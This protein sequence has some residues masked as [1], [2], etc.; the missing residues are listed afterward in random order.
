MRSPR[1]LIYTGVG[2][3][4]FVILPFFLIASAH[5]KKHLPGNDCTVTNISGHA[6]VQYQVE[7]ILGQ[8]SNTGNTYRKKS[9]WIP[10]QKGSKIGFGAL[11]KTDKRSFV[12]IMIKNTAALRINAQSLVKLEQPNKE[13]RIIDLALTE[14][15]VLSWVIAKKSA[16]LQTKPDGYQIRT[17]TAT[18]RVQGTTFAV[19]YLP[20]KKTTKLAVLDGVVHVKSNDHLSSE[21]R[22]HAGKKMQITPSMPHPRLENITS[23]LRK[24]LLEVQ[25][26]KI[27]ETGLDRWNQTMDLVVAS[28]FYNKALNI[29]ANYEMK[30]FKRAIIYYAR[31]VWGDTVP[32]R[33]QAI[34]LEEGDYQDP[35]NSDYLY[36]KLTDKKAVLISAGPDKILHTQDD[37]CVAINL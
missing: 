26:L 12:D 29:I 37:I 14:G 15:Q 30:S 22:V 36:E 32:G 2:M 1:S 27:K 17:P 25:T 11:I 19:D 6:S 8:K 21:T 16:N 9:A 18:A 33:L 7:H 35:W 13:P 28:P 5:V 4:F 23:G 20:S 31:L 3:I 34:E 10:L 24:E